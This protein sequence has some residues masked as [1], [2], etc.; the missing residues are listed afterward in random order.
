M[1]YRIIQRLPKLSFNNGNDPTRLFGRP[2]VV[3]TKFRTKNGV[4]ENVIN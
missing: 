2:T 4:R 1:N 3:G